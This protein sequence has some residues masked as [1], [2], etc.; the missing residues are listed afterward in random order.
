MKRIQKYGEQPRSASGIKC[1]RLMKVNVTCLGL[2]EGLWFGEHHRKHS[3]PDT[4]FSPSNT[5]EEM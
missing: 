4:Q 2:T 3:I 1:Y 5:E